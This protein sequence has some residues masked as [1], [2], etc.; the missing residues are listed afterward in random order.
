MA[1]T[2]TIKKSA[3]KS[4]AKFDADT[5]ERIAT[6]LRELKNNPRPRDARKVESRADT[7]RVRVGVIRIIYEL[8]DNISLVDVVRIAHRGEAYRG[9]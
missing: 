8:H 2:L 3:V 4:I 9:L 7:W 6:V 1:Y 5:K